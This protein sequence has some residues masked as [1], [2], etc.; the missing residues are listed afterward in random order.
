LNLLLIQFLELLHQRWKRILDFYVRYLADDNLSEEVASKLKEQ[1][2]ALG[3]TSGATIFGGGKVV[4][5][6]VPD[7]GEAS[8]VKN[9]VRSVGF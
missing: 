6:C 2:E 8:V 5:V 9:G 3:Y 1:D 7:A 4:L